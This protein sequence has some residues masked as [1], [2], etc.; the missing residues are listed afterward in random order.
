MK[1]STKKQIKSLIFT[2][3]IMGASFAISLALQE[4]LDVKSPITS[5][6]VFGVFLISMVT[7]GYVLGI[8]SAFISVLAVN[9]AFSFPYF[10]FNFTIPENLVSAIIMIVV[11][12]MTS[13]L[14]T[15]LKHW[16]RLQAETEK[17]RIR[18]NLLRAISHD[19][20]TPLTSI[21]G[22]SEALLENSNTLEDEQKNKLIEGIREDSRW[23]IDMVENLLSV[24]RIDEGRINLVKTPTSLDELVDAVIIK[25]KKRYPD[26]KITLELPD[27]VIIIP[28]DAMLINQV[29]MNILENSVKH[30]EG[31]DAIHLRAY[32]EAGLAILEVSDNG[33]GISEEKLANI[34]NGYLATKENGDMQK[35]TAGIGLSVC[36]SIIKAHGGTLTAENKPEGGA[37]FRISLEKEDYNDQ[38]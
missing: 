19:L 17:E 31:S 37:L 6:F 13:A 1:E 18:A 36:S 27:E 9:F 28:M 29:M 14:T 23:L 32:I 26:K 38:Q 35:R 33:C 2:L 22:S 7:D 5:I 21:Y 12:V 25:F 3:A 8:A 34:F 30:A 15:N 20:R 10:A 16:Q 24:T 4:L 11:S